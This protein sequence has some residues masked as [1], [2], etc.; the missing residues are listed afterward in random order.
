MLHHDCDGV[1]ISAFSRTIRAL[2]RSGAAPAIIQETVDMAKGE[3]SSHAPESKAEF[4]G[5]RQRH[6]M[7]E[8]KGG[9]KGGDF[10]V[11]TYPGEKVIKGEQHAAEMLSDS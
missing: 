6:M 11:G 1:V 2:R 4:S 8:G 5:E 9:M 7:G 3:G 10:G